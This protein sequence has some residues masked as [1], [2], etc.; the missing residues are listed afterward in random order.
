MK[1]VFPNSP[2]SFEQ[3]FD[4]SKVV[5]STGEPLVVYHGTNAHAYVEGQIDTFNTRPPSG[6]GAAFFTSDPRMAAQYGEKVYGVCLSLQ[7][8]L[9]VFCD[10]RSWSTMGPMVRIGG[11]VTDPLRQASKK[12]SDEINRLHIEVSEMLGELPEAAG[13]SQPRFSADVT[14]L[15]RMKLGDIPGL[16]ECGIETDAVVKVARRLGFDGVIF[17]DVQDSPTADPGYARTISDVYAVF[18]PAQIRT[19]MAPLHAKSLAA[20]IDA[21]GFVTNSIAGPKRTTGP[22][23]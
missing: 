23:T 19:A 9:I 13:G 16:S 21:R 6:R 12:R 8:P 20:A 10:G 17:R 3:W 4:H 15:D 11:E 2:I 18:D 14:T 22:A 5:D 1:N 7:N